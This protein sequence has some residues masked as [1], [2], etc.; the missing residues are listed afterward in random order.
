MLGR[1]NCDEPGVG[2]ELGRGMVEDV[3]RHRFHKRQ[4][5]D[6]FGHVRQERRHP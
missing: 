1:P 5:V 6:H 4:V 2:E 3:G